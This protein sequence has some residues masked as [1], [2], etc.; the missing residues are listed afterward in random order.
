MRAIETSERRVLALRTKEETMAI[1]GRL[2][3]KSS[4]AAGMT[5]EAAKNLAVNPM[6]KRPAAG[7]TI[8]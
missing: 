7:S 1:I 3:C 8:Q 6:D 4:G 5:W 2:S